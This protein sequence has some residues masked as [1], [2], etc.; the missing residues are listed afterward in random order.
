M[1]AGPAGKQTMS[2]LSDNTAFEA[3]LKTQCAVVRRDLDYKHER[4]RL[5]PFIFLRATFFRWARK[6]ESICPELARAPRVLAVG[7]LH[8]ENF[9]TWRDAEGRLI[10]GVND[11][12]DAALIPYAF[13]LLRLA[14]S[15][16][17]APDM[18]VGNREASE[19]ILAGYRRGLA[20][21]RPTLLD[22]Q[23]TWMRPFVACTDA[24]RRR[25]WQ[26]VDALRPA[27]LPADA[28]KALEK[29]LPRSASKLR[30]APRRKGVGSLGRPRY[31][32][33][34]DWGGGRILRE[35]KALVPSAWDWAHGKADP[36]SRFLDLAEGKFRARDPFLEI[37]DRFVVRRSAPDAR[38]I[39]LGRGT[40]RGMPAALLE[41]M[42]F[43]VGAIH[44][45]SASKRAAVLRDLDSRPADWLRQAVKAA[46]AAVERDFETWGAAAR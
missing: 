46:A 10:W 22:E 13:D 12:D 40:I 38:K 14:T 41:A 20:G 17:L 1:G 21:P 3:W 7:D 25:F 28:M 9:G 16:R 11:F 43:D 30:F 39:E 31:V 33:S 5:D 37:R 24:E 18:P 27:K 4:M 32:V 34:A 44:A 6:I 29:G 45:A 42:S 23:E 2:F 36:R 8:L 26:E 35:V 19:A 15:A